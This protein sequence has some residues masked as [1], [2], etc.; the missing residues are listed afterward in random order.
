M[1]NSPNLNS[2]LSAIEFTFCNCC[3]FSWIVFSFSFIAIIFS[4]LF[5]CRGKLWRFLFGLHVHL[6]WFRRWNLRSCMDWWYEKCWW[7]LWKKWG[8]IFFLVYYNTGYPTWI[9]VDS[10]F[11]RAWPGGLERIFFFANKFGLNDA[12]KFKIDQDKKTREIK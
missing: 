7:C 2:L 8:K 1:W 4:F 6:S 10:T 11:Y 3:F 9:W 12:R 5:F